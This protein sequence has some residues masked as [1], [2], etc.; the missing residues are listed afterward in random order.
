[1]QKFKKKILKN[2]VIDT[3]NKCENIQIKSNKS[4]LNFDYI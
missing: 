4:N 2:Y 3:A 1:M